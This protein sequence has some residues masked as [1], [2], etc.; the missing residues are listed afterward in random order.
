MPGPQRT[1]DA[2]YEVV[3]GKAIIIDP[4]GTEVVTLN[5]LGTLVWQ[6]L[7]GG[8]EVGTLADELAGRF[9]GVSRQQLEDDVRAFL[10]DL[11]DSKLIVGRF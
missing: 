9:P 8:H 4:A 1:E 7:D 6:S 3:E 10:S 2:Q 11:E 5:E